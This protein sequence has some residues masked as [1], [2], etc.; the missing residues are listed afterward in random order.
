MFRNSIYFFCAYLLVLAGCGGLPPDDVR[1][2]QVATTA[3]ALDTCT[4]ASLDWNGGTVAPSTDA[5]KICAGPIYYE[6]QCYEGRTDSLCGSTGYIQKSCYT[7]CD[8][9]EYVTVEKSVQVYPVV[10]YTE[11]VCEPGTCSGGWCDKP[12]CHDRNTYSYERPC[13]DAVQRL[14]NAETDAAHR[15]QVQSS[16]TYPA[17][18]TVDAGGAQPGTCS[19]T[20]KNVWKRNHYAATDPHCAFTRK[21]CD[22]TEKPLYNYCRDVSFGNAPVD[23]CGTRLRRTE[24]GLSLQAARDE[25]AKEWKDLGYRTATADFKTAP[26][27]MTCEQE[28]TVSGRFTC[29]DKSLALANLMTVGT[30]RTLLQQQVVRRMKLLFELEGEQLSEEQRT[31][32]RSLYKD[33]P[34]HQLTCEAGMGFTALTTDSSCGDMATLNA[35]LNMCARLTGN[36]VSA[37]SADQSHALCSSLLT[38]V[39]NVPVTPA[40]KGSEYRTAYAAIMYKLT[41]RQ[42]TSIALE[43]S[44]GALK[45][46]DV[47]RA[48]RYIDNW[49]AQGRSRLSDEAEFR[50]QLSRLLADFWTAAYATKVVYARTIDSSSSE[51]QI[52]AYLKDVGSKSLEVEREVL[53]QL[54]TDDSEGH[55]MK[56]EPMLLVMGDGFKGLQSRLTELIPLH[57]FACRFKQCAL[58]EDRSE[59]SLMWALLGAMHDS[60][61]LTQVNTQRAPLGSKT[62]SQ[63]ATA[64]RTVFSLLASNHSAL[65]MAMEDAL[66]HMP[67]PGEPDDWQRILSSGMSMETPGSAAALSLIIQDASFR[68]NSY[69]K[70]VYLTPGLSRVLHSGISEGGRAALISALRSNNNALTAA[71]DKYKTGRYSLISNLQQ[72]LSG[73][74]SSLRLLNQMYTRALSMSQLSQDLQGLR[75]SLEVQ[76]GRFADFSSAFNELLESEKLDGG[77]LQY[78]RSDIPLSISGADSE[79]STSYTNEQGAPVALT[80]VQQLAM[81]DKLKAT[82]EPWKLT[83]SPG[84]LLNIQTTGSWTPTCSLS[85][86][87][88]ITGETVFSSQVKLTSNSGGVEEL[89]TTG[90]EGFSVEWSSTGYTSFSTASVRQDGSYYENSDSHQECE[91]TQFS[92]NL[93]LP[94]AVPSP[95]QLSLGYSRSVQDC[96]SYSHGTQGSRTYSHSYSSGGDN[97]TSASFSRGLRLSNT[98]LPSLPVGSLVLVEM[99]QGVTDLAQAKDLHIIKSGMDSFIPKGT[100]NSDLYLV[101]ND[102]S[103][104]SSVSSAKTLTVALKRLEPI[105]GRRSQQLKDAMLQTLAK[106]RAKEAEILK[107]GRLLPGDRSSLRADALLALGSLTVEPIE[108]RQL[109]EAWIDKEIAILE[110]KV[111]ILTIERSMN[112]L[113]LEM[114]GLKDEIANAEA[115]SRLYR[116]S[117]TWTLR[118]V[119]ARQLR[120]AG[121]IANVSIKK[122]VNDFF[123][124]LELRY[125]SVLKEMNN[126]DAP[127]YRNQLN[128]IIDTKLSD[129]VLTQVSNTSAAMAAILTAYENQSSDSLIK[130]PFIVALR[131]KRPSAT[132]LASPWRIADDQ[133]RAKEI[134]DAV[135]TGGRVSL[136]LTPW[137]LFSNPTAPA[138]LGCSEASAVIEAMGLHFAWYH[139]WASN[140]NGLRLDVEF[141]EQQLFVAEQGPISY[142]LNNNTWRKQIVPVTAYSTYANAV[143]SFNTVSLPMRVGEGLSPFTKM[144]INFKSLY[145]TLHA[146]GLNMDEADEVAVLFKLSPRAAGNVK[147]PGVCN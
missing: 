77:L 22:D 61:L 87:H 34:D 85:L 114:K 95:V 23:A 104:C 50:S 38:A 68:T 110:K 132:A 146:Q 135:D 11:V 52:N 25:A 2:S 124:L 60:S 113:V 3:Q 74:A 39:A 134:W 100:G 21:D 20:L 4:L 14:I 126:A 1:P 115:S 128:A 8:V 9:E 54:F 24:F 7:E 15:G 64:W 99:P 127:Y 136:H 143:D 91:G 79:L 45:T 103:R 46:S 140:L 121:D 53:T 5:Q 80:G 16:Q 75:Y 129:G 144:S 35:N 131:F 57:D 78:N 123:P 119:D 118:D 71:I 105:N 49:Y 109:F 73:T 36:H 70:T 98:P 10:T 40:C 86:A 41:Q 145:N 133:M 142:S 141:D 33:F 101:V 26:T 42:A 18:Y 27:C 102:A 106:L 63:E 139:P 58:P 84:D 62:V 76:E 72:E 97:R 69:E 137:D 125:P 130:P 6:T 56:H 116:L 43:P 29:L 90:P 28:T 66:L 92:A 37:E 120:D 111:E 65:R 30:D 19:I 94:P 51:A 88:T 44:T 147:W 12:E 108:F 96:D 55:L 117:T 107:Q 112:Q 31:F 48:L 81:K 93:G 138:Q 59:M 122:M 17:S 32:A 82:G 83:V 13:K 89:I 47:R 67:T